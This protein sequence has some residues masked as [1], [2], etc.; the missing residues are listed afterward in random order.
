MGFLL[1]SA[2]C[3]QCHLFIGEKYTFEITNYSMARAF[4]FL[5]N[6]FLFHVRAKVRMLVEVIYMYIEVVQHL[7]DVWRP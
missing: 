7:V 4:I 3:S 1:V 2:P 5:C 6:T